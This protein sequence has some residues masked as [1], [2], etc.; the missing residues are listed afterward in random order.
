[1]ELIIDPKPPKKVYEYDFVLATGMLLPVT[2]DPTAGDTINFGDQ[3]VHIHLVPKQHKFDITKMT[4]A[5]DIT[6]F[7]PHLASVQKRERE[8]IDMTPE[9]R[10]QYEQTL[11]ELAGST[12][13]S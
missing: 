6:I 10:Y 7:V 9:Q 8:M 1:M 12:I 4:P 11:K 13:S 3:Q 2:V 5:E